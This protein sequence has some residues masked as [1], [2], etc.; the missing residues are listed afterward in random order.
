MESAAYDV[1]GRNDVPYIDVTG[2]MDMAGGT[3]SLF[4]LNRDL[5]KARDVEIIWRDTPP[6]KVRLSH[7]L[8]GRDLKASNS[9]KNPN[10]VAPKSFD[11]PQIKNRTSLELP[12]RSY[13]VLQLEL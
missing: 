3:I 13:T 2:T 6:K 9:F 4:F 12:A 7:I 1:R 10:N 11:P 8:T 5:N